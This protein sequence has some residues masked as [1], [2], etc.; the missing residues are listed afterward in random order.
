V[1]L[2]EDSRQATVLPVWH[3]VHRLDADPPMGNRAG[4]HGP[5][6]GQGTVIV[7]RTGAAGTGNRW[8]VRH[9]GHRI[10]AAGTEHWPLAVAIGRE[11]VLCFDVC[12]YGYVGVVRREA[13]LIGGSGLPGFGEP[14]RRSRTPQ[15]HPWGVRFVRTCL[16]IDLSPMVA[17]TAG[18]GK[19]DQTF[20][21][22]QEELLRSSSHELL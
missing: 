15:A 14:P 6:L 20:A 3:L 13:V 2:L 19:S 9:L 1:R 10:G 7:V 8:F 16:D 17:G 22:Q 18:E 4:G 12:A 21:R 5:R 11:S